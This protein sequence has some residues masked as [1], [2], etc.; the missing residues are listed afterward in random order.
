MSRVKKEIKCRYIV[1]YTVINYITFLQ[2]NSI[3]QSMVDLL[4]H[5]ILD[6]TK[7]T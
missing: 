7:V 6:V 1:L 4:V 3:N 2:R 5:N